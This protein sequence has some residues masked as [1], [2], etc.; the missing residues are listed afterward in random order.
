MTA[1]PVLRRTAQIP[2]HPERQGQSAT[3]G[4]RRPTGLVPQLNASERYANSALTCPLAI[5]IL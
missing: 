4:K 3:T 2:G 5:V 1:K